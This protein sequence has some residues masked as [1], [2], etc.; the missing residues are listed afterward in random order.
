MTQVQNK[1][2]SF[3]VWHSVIGTGAGLAFVA[4]LMWFDVGRLYSLVAASD[5]GLLALCILAAFFAITFGSVQVGVALMMKR[6][7]SQGGG[8][9]RPFALTMPKGLQAPIA[10]RAPARR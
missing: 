4:L 5:V 2:V 6:D 8:K 10:V 3:V 1:L 9:P 7:W